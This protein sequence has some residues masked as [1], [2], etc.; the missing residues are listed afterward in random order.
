MGFI[1]L[2]LLALVIGGV[3]AFVGKRQAGG[4]SS[5]PGSGFGGGSAQQSYDAAADAGAEAHRWV[6]LL[7]GSLSTLDAG[8]NQAARQALADAG[9]RHRAAQGQLATAYSP[10]QYALVTQSAVEG[11]HHVRT[12]RTALGLDP[13]PA[14][15]TTGL[16]GG[17]VT[18][19]GRTYTASAQPG[20]ANPYYYPGGVVGGRTVPGGWYSQPWWKTALVAGA[21]GVGGMLLADAIFEGFHHP[22]GPGPGGP[23]GPGGFG[24]GGFGGPGPF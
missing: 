9:E 15:P 23:G 4:A 18:V 11:L 3:V 12:A 22:H 1:A 17:Q 6:E 16:G 5:P 13:G 2:V 21:A 20:A 7:G 10:A 24:F 19:G 8:G 14:L